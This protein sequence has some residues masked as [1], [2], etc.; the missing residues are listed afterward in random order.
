ME[1]NKTNNEKLKK[2]AAEIRA[3][4]VA[5]KKTKDG[6]KLSFQEKLE[7]A[8]ISPNHK[9]VIQRIMSV[10]K[11]N[12]NQIEDKHTETNADEIGEIADQIIQKAL[13]GKYGSMRYDQK[14]D[15]NQGEVTAV[16]DEINIKEALSNPLSKEFLTGKRLVDEEDIKKAYDMYIG[17]EIDMQDYFKENMSK[18]MKFKE[19]DLSSRNIIEPSNLNE[20]LNQSFE[21]FQKYYEATNG[22]LDDNCDISQDIALME[23]VQ[24][25]SLVKRKRYKIRGKKINKNSKD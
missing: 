6:K 1:I 17:L 12:S 7:N 23:F 20:A 5:K 25:K 14:E 9:E 11:K 4:G 21:E 16:K 19:D 2:I 10:D 8:V 24:D 22:F 15:I 13:D 3:T 18:I